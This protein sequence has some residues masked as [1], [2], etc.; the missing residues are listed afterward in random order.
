MTKNISHMKECAS[1][2][3]KFLE[4]DPQK[5]FGT[6]IKYRQFVLLYACEVST[7]RAKAMPE[8]DGAIIWKT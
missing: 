7:A 3:T 8:R 1:R 6:G 2:V 5:P 4:T